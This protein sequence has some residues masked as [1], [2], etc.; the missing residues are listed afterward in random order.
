MKI[1]TTNTRFLNKTAGNL[2]VSLLKEDQELEKH[3]SLLP[4]QNNWNAKFSIAE[5]NVTR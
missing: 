5:I 3:V 1:Q 4:L 2:E